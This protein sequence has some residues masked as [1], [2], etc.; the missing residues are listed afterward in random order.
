M[1]RITL[2]GA[3]GKVGHHILTEALDRGHQVTAVMR[4]PQTASALDPRAQIIAGDVTDP[5]HVV[6]AVA[7]GA[8]AVVLA[9]G[10][11]APSLWRS[12]AQTVTETL[13]TLTQPRPRIIHLGGGATLTLP[14]GTR[15]LDQPHFPDQYRASAQG[16]AD[17]LDWYRTHAAQ[18]GV[19]WTYISPP[20][21]KF[22]PGK[23][24]GVYRTGLDQP[25]A[26][27]GGDTV[28]SYADMAVVILDEIKHP[29]FLNTRF[30]A[31]Y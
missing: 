21:V 5:D 7:A 9:V 17:A 22:A 18:C 26:T 29:R 31:A 25:V 24:R 23:R 3:T 1:S 13:A 2:F 30:T 8:D 19:T 4:R 16:Q 20:P 6:T 10:G 28:L 15:I 11:G 14:D 27:Q 12:A